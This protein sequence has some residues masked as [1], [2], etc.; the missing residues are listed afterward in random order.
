[1]GFP[2]D[3]TLKVKYP[4]KGKQIYLGSFKSLNDAIKTRE[5]YEIKRQIKSAQ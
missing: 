3:F 2:S 1:M 5:D 4:E